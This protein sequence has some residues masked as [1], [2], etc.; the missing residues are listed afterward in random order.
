MFYLLIFILRI[1][2]NFKRTGL[3]FKAEQEIVLKH[4]LGD[5]LQGHRKDTV[6]Y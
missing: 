5:A 1:T 2:M 3:L 6:K 4:Q